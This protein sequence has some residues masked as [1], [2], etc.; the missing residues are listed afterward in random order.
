ME[1]HENIESRISGIK[2]LTSNI[3]L[4]IYINTFMH[5]YTYGLSAILHCEIK[6]WYFDQ[7][8]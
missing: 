5:R 4:Y 6:M 8:Y 2:W 7:E 3:F 1:K